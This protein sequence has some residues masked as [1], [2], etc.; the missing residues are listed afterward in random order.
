MQADEV[1]GTFRFGELGLNE[2]DPLQNFELTLDKFY[3]VVKESIGT[4]AP[5]ELVQLGTIALP[6]DLGDK[7]PW[8][9]FFNLVKLGNYLVQQTPHAD[10]TATIDSSLFREYSYFVS[11]LARTIEL[12]V[13]SD[14]ENQQIKLLETKIENCAELI[15]AYQEKRWKAWLDYCKFNNVSSG[16]TTIWVEF[17]N[18]H[19]TSNKI[20]D[21]SEQQD[22][23]LAQTE[24]IRNRQYENEEDKEVMDTWKLLNNGAATLKL[25]RVEDKLYA[26]EDQKFNLTYFSL[27][28]DAPSDIFELMPVI[29]PGVTTGTVLTSTSGSL[30][31]EYSKSSKSKTDI[32]TEWNT[33]VSGSGSG[34][35]F[36]QKP[37]SFSFS[38]DSKTTVK[39]D[40]AKVVKIGFGVDYIQAVDFRR[41]WFNPGLFRHSKVIQN[42]DS[43]SRYLGPRGSLL[44][45]P[46]RVILAR[47]FQISFEKSE[48]F[49]YDYTS[50]IKSDASG[51][52]SVKVLGVSFGGGG[53][54]DSSKRTETN[55]L[56]EQQG[57]KLT[58]KDGANIRLLGYFVTYNRPP[59]P[60]DKI[61]EQFLDDRYSVEL[62]VKPD[63]VT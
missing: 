49:T 52:A 41:P 23:A 57:V 8:F 6:V 16:D 21:L 7:Y 61:Y 13:L 17:R 43:F 27:L 39:S 14:S 3:G 36:V 48:N 28:G 24:L 62:N 45:T 46:S 20:Q 54:S 2:F 38:E 29:S 55:Q 58:L 15:D 40:F 47:G 1:T 19:Y 42:F 33:K 11:Q 34:G 37:Y 32:V 51:S 4:V 10:Y 63:S 59:L 30:S 31:V 53:G 44:F 9:S 22:E 50:A 35:F 5:N 56:V 26:P 12:R 60:S 25:P 18:G